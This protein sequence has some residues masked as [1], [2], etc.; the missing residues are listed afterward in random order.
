MKTLFRII[1]FIY[2]LITGILILALGLILLPLEK[3]K[4]SPRWLYKAINMPLIWLNNKW[5]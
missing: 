3:I 2:A 5:K 1:A 4:I